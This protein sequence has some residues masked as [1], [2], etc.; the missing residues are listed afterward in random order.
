MMVKCT[1]KWTYCQLCNCHRLVSES[2]RWHKSITWKLH[3]CYF[4]VMSLVSRPPRTPAKWPLGVTFVITSQVVTLIVPAIQL[5]HIFFASTSLYSK[6]FFTYL[7]LFTLISQADVPLSC[8]KQLSRLKRSIRRFT[9]AGINVFRSAF[10][11]C[12]SLLINKL[13]FSKF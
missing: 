12:S 10:S 7:N 8:W 3:K 13:S 5:T 1:K 6:S 2:V 4:K 9:A 11:T